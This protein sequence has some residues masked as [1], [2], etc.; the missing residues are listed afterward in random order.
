MIQ[1]VNIFVLICRGKRGLGRVGW[2]GVG[3]FGRQSI[4]VLGDEKEHKS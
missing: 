1:L 2:G 3:N 4:L